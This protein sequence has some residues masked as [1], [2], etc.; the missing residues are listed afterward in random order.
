MPAPSH[1]RAFE[2]EVARQ[3]ILLLDG[4]RDR[5]AVLQELTRMIDSKA[6]EEL[7]MHLEEKL[8]ELGKLGLLLA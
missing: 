7:T 6:K 4:T 5:G 8:V 1:R 3:M 2:D